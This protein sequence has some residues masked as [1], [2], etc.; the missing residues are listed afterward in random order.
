MDREP[1]RPA[2]IAEARATLIGSLVL[3]A[4][5]IALY[6]IFA[7]SVDAVALQVAG[8]ARRANEV[9]GGRAPAFRSALGWD[10]VLIAGYTA[11]LVWICQLG[12]RVFWTRPLSWAAVAGG[13]LAVGAGVFNVAQDVLL[14]VALRRVPVHTA[15]PLK[16]AQALSFAKFSSLL[17]AAVIG[18]CA[19]GTALGRLAFRASI[20]RK[21][22]A[23]EPDDVIPPPPMEEGFR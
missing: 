11:S 16:V 18:A 1:P 22:E 21:M 15:W 10:F 4:A 14:L 8:T 3:L 23:L 6:A 12:R 19:W 17:F 7:P 9:I 20:E 5:G 13:G 2:S